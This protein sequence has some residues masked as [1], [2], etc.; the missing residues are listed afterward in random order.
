LS[1]KG[2]EKVTFVGDCADG[3]RRISSFLGGFLA[4]GV[5]GVVG[6]CGLVVRC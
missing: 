3:G 5:V 2:A 6:D 4:F 1:R